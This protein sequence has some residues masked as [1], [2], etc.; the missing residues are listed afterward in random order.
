MN[1]DEMGFSFKAGEN[2]VGGR[3]GGILLANDFEYN[4]EGS[5]KSSMKV[6]LF[7]GTTLGMKHF[8]HLLLCQELQSILKLKMSFCEE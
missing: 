8:H 3:I 7:A 2:G 6:T 5:E 1:F 4:G